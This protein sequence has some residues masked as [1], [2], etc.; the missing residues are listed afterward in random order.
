MYPVLGVNNIFF[1]FLCRGPDG[2]PIRG[3][4][5]S[6]N[7]SEH[8]SSET[9]SLKEYADGETGKFDEEGSFIGQYGD[10]KK[11]RQPDDEQGGGA[12]YSTFV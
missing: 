7:D 9:D 11:Q 3:S 8:G 4:Q 2:E 5:G 10:N 6:L 1:I 12:A